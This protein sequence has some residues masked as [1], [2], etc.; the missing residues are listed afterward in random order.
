[1]APSGVRKRTRTTALPPT[2]PNPRSVVLSNA[3]PLTC[4]PS[5]VPHACIHVSVYVRAEGTSRFAT[6]Q[7]G[8]GAVSEGGVLP[9]S[10]A[11][12]GAALGA[13]RA[14]VSRSVAVAGTRSSRRVPLSSCRA[15][16]TRASA[17]ASTVHEQPPHTACAA[18][19]TAAG[20]LDQVDPS[21]RRQVGQAERDTQVQRSLLVPARAVGASAAQAHG[22]A[23]RGGTH[24][25]AWRAG[26][27]CSL[28]HTASSTSRSGVA[29]VT[30]TACCS[31]ASKPYTTVTDAMHHMQGPR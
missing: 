25:S 4:T 3:S 6:I 23:G 18:G 20:S 21:A 19:L 16:C 13:H 9:R 22:A 27:R 24:S 11:S 1:M 2:S 14:S 29:G 5:S 31:R 26:S 17:A 15:M 7:T 28:V 12:A 30:L 8:R 10:A